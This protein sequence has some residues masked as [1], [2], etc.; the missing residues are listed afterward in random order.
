MMNGKQQLQPH[1]FVFNE[2]QNSQNSGSKFSSLFAFPEGLLVFVTS[3]KW[4]M[5]SWYRFLKQSKPSLRALG[6]RTIEFRI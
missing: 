5:D 2:G 1:H 3:K 4:G 6:R